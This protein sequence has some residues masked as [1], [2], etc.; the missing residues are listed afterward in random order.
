MLPEVFKILIVCV[1]T[2]IHACACVL[3]VAAEC[4]GVGCVVFLKVGDVFTS[5]GGDQGRKRRGDD[6]FAGL[7]FCFVECHAFFQLGLQV[8]LS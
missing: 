4:V 7:S 6:L 1:I 2:G 8:G 3:V 5:E